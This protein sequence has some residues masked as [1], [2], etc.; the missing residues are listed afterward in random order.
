MI[1]ITQVTMAVVTEIAVALMTKI[2]H[3]SQ[4]LVQSVNYFLEIT[5]EAWIGLQFQF[6]GG[7][8]VKMQS[9]T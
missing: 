6:H 7:L 1:L 4:D 8:Y 3:S 5:G 9:L 2:I